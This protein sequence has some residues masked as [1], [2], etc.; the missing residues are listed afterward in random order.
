M[1]L[2]NETKSYSVDDCKVSKMLTDTVAGATYDTAVDLP[3]IRSIDFGQ[4][5]TT[6]DLRGDNKILA[7]HS[8]IEKISVKVE[9]AK[10][11]LAALAVL[12]GGS[13]ADNGTTP[14]QTKTL[15]IKST[16][17][18]PY[19][20]I[21]AQVLETDI[22]DLHYIGYKMKVTDIS[23]SWKDDDFAIVSFSAEGIGRTYDD[24]MVD[25]LE[26][27]TAASI[28]TSADTTPPTVSSTSPSDGDA[29]TAITAN[30]EWT[31]SEELQPASVNAGSCMLIKVSDGTVIPGA[32][33][34][35]NN[36]ASTKVTLDPTSS[37]AN[38]TAY[39]AVLTTQVRDLAG[40]A[41]ANASVINFT[42]VA[43]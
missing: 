12:Q 23:I 42:T 18:V 14:N 29:S 20:K 34:L 6:K 11:P 32:V 5:F 2:T 39:I 21:E 16:D 8:K 37:L 13:V 35:V 22:G 1:S 25:I 7:Q 26:N 43:P 41:L 30:I 28:P 4:K 15:T 31:M 40:N 33:T 24:N 10:I 27:E 19:F 17:T 38:S 36:G 9:N 3:G